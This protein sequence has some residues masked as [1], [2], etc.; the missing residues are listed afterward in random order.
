MSF[1]VSVLLYSELRWVYNL[2]EIDTVLLT[3]SSILGWVQFRVGQ[4]YVVQE[5]PEPVRLFM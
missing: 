2:G 4:A 1:D 3:Q 5:P